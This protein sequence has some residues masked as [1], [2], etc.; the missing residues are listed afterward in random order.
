M[1]KARAGHNRADGL[2][3]EI[4]LYIGDKR[5]ADAMEREAIAQLEGAQ[6]HFTLSKS[7][8]PN[9]IRYC[10][11]NPNQPAALAILHLI[12]L[13]SDN[14][15][16]CCWLSIGRMAELF[17][18][19][20][21]SIRESIDRLE[22]AGVLHVERAEG[23]PSRYWPVVP[24]ALAEAGVSA[25]NF[26]QAL[27]TAP[28]PRGRPPK[29]EVAQEPVQPEP[30]NPGTLVQGLNE[31]TPERSD[32]K[33]RNARAKTPERSRTHSI[34]SKD[35]LSKDITRGE[36]QPSV[37]MPSPYRNRDPFNLNVHDTEVHR[38]CRWEG[39]R[40]V[41]LNGFRAE[42]EA[43]L[44]TD[45]LDLV[46][47]EI[48]A[49]VGPGVR[50]WVLKTKVRGEVARVARIRADHRQARAR[51]WGGS[52]KDK[53]PPARKFSVELLPPTTDEAEIARRFETFAQESPE[54]IAKFG[55]ERAWSLFLK[56][57]LR[58]R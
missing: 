23:L 19:T 11:A 49:R 9:D 39:D 55:R 41:V 42:L 34:L 1:D 52:P 8:I 15:E 56:T 4:T 5:L 44:G 22:A 28:G 43:M 38:D 25:I 26:V 53:S 45:D 31:K 47:I 32:Q 2:F 58:R 27:T 30:D 16:G 57:E 17:G 24:S 46:L 50:G 12:T 6:R 33:P 48:A 10:R 13:L 40:L 35:S 51:P 21:R 7:T 29:V 54:T 3:D 18:R 37:E 14:N 36:V 20:E